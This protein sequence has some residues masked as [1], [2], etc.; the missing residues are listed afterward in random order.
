MTHKLYREFCCFASKLT[1]SV[2]LVAVGQLSWA[3]GNI[4]PEHKYACS[5]NAGWVNFRPTGGGVAVRGTGLSGYAWAENMGW[6]KLGSGDGPYGNTGPSDWGV[7]VQIVGGVK[8]LSGFSWSETC[9]WINFNPTYSQVTIDPV[10]GLFDG[11]AWSENVGWIHFQNASP[12]YDVKMSNETLPN[13]DTSNSYAFAENAGWLNF[14]PVDGGVAVTTAGLSGYAWAENAGWIKLGSGSGP[15]G[16]TAPSDWGVNVHV[17]GGVVLLSGYA[18]GENCGWI[19]FSPTHS[20]VTIDSLTGRF[21]GYAWS[22]NV[23]WR[24]G[25][26]SLDHEMQK[27][28]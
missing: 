5:E 24:G 6:I 2:V 17:G 9:G 19:N 27:L 12:A 23:G 7:N 14:N 1:L 25:P 13:I 3:A 21:D 11:Y 26:H 28:S 16:N 22:E 4:D 15:Y 8:N 18:W 20:Q 10:T